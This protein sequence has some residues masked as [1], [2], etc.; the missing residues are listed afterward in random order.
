MYSLYYLFPIQ[1]N[2]RLDNF[3]FNQLR[4]KR[5][6]VNVLD[7]RDY[8]HSLYREIGFKL[9]YCPNEENYY[10]RPVCLP[11]FSELEEH[12]FDYVV[13]SVNEFFS[14]NK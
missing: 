13:D 12:D 14:H 6:S 2:S 5:I 10:E 8:L 4:A 3:F 7:K 9:G 11:I 1:I